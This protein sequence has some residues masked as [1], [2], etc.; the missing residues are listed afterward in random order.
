MPTLTIDVNVSVSEDT[1]KEFLKEVASILAKEIEKPAEWM[2]IELKP[3]QSM[4]FDGKFDPM[5]F[6]VLSSIGHINKEKN[7]NYSAALAAVITKHLKIA[8]DRIYII[9]Q[10]I[11][12]QNWLEWYFTWIKYQINKWIRVIQFQQ[13]QHYDDYYHFFSSSIGMA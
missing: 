9:F 8:A 11:A 7:K 12:A 10:D 4:I 6:C 1:R 13:Q 2:M 5:A 3:D